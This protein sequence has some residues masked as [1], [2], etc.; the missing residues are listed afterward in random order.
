MAL[1]DMVGDC[2]GEF[3]ADGAPNVDGGNVWIGINVAL[4]DMVGDW[5]ADGVPN[6]DGGKVWMGISETLGDIAGSFVF[7]EEVG[8]EET[9]EL[10]TGA[11]VAPI[12][13][14]D[15]KSDSIRVSETV[16]AVVDGADGP[17]GMGE[18]DC[19]LVVG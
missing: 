12:G 3:V 16:G 15:G 11:I 2:A 14:S 4:G 19:V 10:P 9:G 7:G 13:A 18:G 17:P 5:V 1:G 6:A 8:V